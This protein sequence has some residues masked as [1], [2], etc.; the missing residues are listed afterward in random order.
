[1]ETIII[2]WLWIQAMGFFL[3]YG[4]GALFLGGGVCVG[5]GKLAVEQ[6]A[7]MAGDKLTKGEVI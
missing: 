5:G 4:L 3:M 6:G 7:T 1:M 2:L